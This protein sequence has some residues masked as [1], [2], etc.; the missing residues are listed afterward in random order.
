MANEEIITLSLNLEISKEQLLLVIEKGIPFVLNLNLNSVQL[1]SERFFHENKEKILFLMQSLENVEILTQTRTLLRGGRIE[2][3][4]QMAEKWKHIRRFPGMG[5]KSISIL[6]Q[7]FEN[8]GLDL[9]NPKLL[10]IA[11]A[12]ERVNK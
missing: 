11:A 7:L 4:F 3:L 5:G 9:N 6:T 2:Y 10:L 12:K 8:V 1:E